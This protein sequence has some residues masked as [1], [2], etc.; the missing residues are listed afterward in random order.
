MLLLIF[1]VVLC[2]KHLMFFLINVVAQ[3]TAYYDV[4]DEFKLHLDGDK[5][6]AVNQTVRVSGAQVLFNIACL[7]PCT[8]T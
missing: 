2:Q 3:E 5:R 6:F 8:E 7:N 4:C 1:M